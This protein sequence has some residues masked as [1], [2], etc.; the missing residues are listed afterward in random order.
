M[1]RNARQR[2]IIELIKERD[3]ETQEEL[4]TLLQQSGFNITQA[5]VSRDIKDLGLVKS[6][7]PSGSY[8]YSP[9]ESARPNTLGKFGNMFR[10]AV[11]AISQ[12]G[13]LIVVRTVT[14]TA[15][16]AGAFVDSMSYEHVL[17]SVAGDDT[18][19]IVCDT[20]EN[21]ENVKI[22]LESNLE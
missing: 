1:T 7:T 5:T 2:K 17:G 14:G 4:V 12:A 9:V 3:I 6:Q 15:G 18:I 8:K 16:T 13:N 10:Q 11:V 20:E 21:A 19:L 22:Q